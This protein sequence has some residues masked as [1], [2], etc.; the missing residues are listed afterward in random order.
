MVRGTDEIW[1]QAGIGDSG[2]NYNVNIVEKSGM[3]QEVVANADTWKS[4]IN[5]T[6]HAA[7]YG[8]YFDTDKAVLKPESE[9]AL[10]E[11]VKLP[12]QN[13]SLTVF[14]VGTPIQPET[15]SIT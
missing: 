1:V 12:N 3:Q 11:I 13:P 14:V 7:I 6:G 15:F 9:P 10:Q 2:Y 4:D 8:I 5:A